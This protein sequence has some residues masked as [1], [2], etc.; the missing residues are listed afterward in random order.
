MLGLLVMGWLM[1]YSLSVAEFEVDSFFDFHSYVGKHTIWLGIAVFIAFLI[2][3]INKKF[4]TIVSYPFYGLTILLLLFVLFFGDEINGTKSWFS[5]GP[6]NVQPSELAKL[7]T[8]LALSAFLST[9]RVSLKRTIN[10]LLSISIFLAPAFFVILQ[11]DAGTAFIFFSF[12]IV[13]YRAG[14]NPMLY[15]LGFGLTALVILSL[16]FNPWQLLMI[17]LFGIST[18]IFFKELHRKYAIPLTT[19]VL[20]TLLILNSE[21]H[22]VLATMISG[23]MVVGALS[24]SMRK[25]SYRSGISSLVLCALAA[26]V[27]F[28]SNFGY[29]HILER[30]QRDRINVWLK[31]SECDPHGSLYNLLQSKT[32]I[33]SGGFSGKGFG[34]GTMTKFNYIPE[35]NTDFIFC[36]V[37]EEHGFLGALLLIVLYSILLIRLLMIAERQRTDFERYFT[38][39]AFG[40]L[41]FHFIINTGMTMGLLP[42]VGIPLPFISYG[43][44]S[45]IVF[46]SLLAIVM[47]FDSERHKV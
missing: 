29:N 47:R 22:I 13:L 15:V 41:F 45:L 8:C 6:F 11:P 19:L 33:A 2:F 7:S 46:I 31:P 5:L 44:S 12:L 30:H 16:L 3:A 34:K 27:I 10:I 18:I 24:L 42:V 21:E 28:F 32:A 25:G 39:G 1:Q 14:L 43:G 35:Q 9:Y 36:T 40:L 20:I 23:L 38:Y 17:I 37:S 4:W 26:G